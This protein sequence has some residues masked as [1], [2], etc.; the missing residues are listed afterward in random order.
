MNHDNISEEKGG[1][2]LFEQFIL[3]AHIIVVGYWLGSEFVIN[4]TYRY[5]CRSSQMP[6]DERARLMSHVMD[7][8]Q[9]VRYA[10][11][12][13]ATLGTM[14]AALY[15]YVPGGATLASVAGILGII[16]FA[17]VEGIH[18]S[19]SGPVGNA[20]AAIDR[21]L[22]YFAVGA[23][24]ALFASVAFGT[25]FLSSWLAWKL[26][27]FAAV[28]GCGLLI[29]LELLKFFRVWKQIADEGSTT[30]RESEIRHLYWTSTLALIYLWM[31]ILLIV[32]VS[33]VKPLSILSV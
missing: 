30:E 11:V 20:L 17:F 2:A 18:R 21:G 1:D 6:F 24:A 32:T 22:R 5:V 25:I 29:R 13:Q 16:W 15:G 9:H 4:S 23:L 31:F 7:V 28:I 27:F 12:L 8:D 14:L 3:L 19:R 26:L 10:L 33:F